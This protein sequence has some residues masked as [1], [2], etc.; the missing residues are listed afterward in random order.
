VLIALPGE[1]VRTAARAGILA[2]LLT[3]A[4]PLSDPGSF[5]HALGAE[6]HTTFV[7]AFSAWW[8]V[9][10]PVHLA[11]GALAAVRALPLG[12]S[13]STATL[14]T[15]ISVLGVLGFTGYRSRRGGGAWDPLALLALLGVVRCFCDTTKL[16]Y[17]YV[18]ALIPLVAW[19]VAA[20][21]RPP[22]LGALLSV[23]TALMPS[24]TLYAHRAALNAVWVGLAV[25]LIVYLR[26]RAFAVWRPPGA[27]AE[28]AV[29][30]GHPARA[31]G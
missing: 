11:G 4:L 9:S 6:G 18:A 3:L 28:T 7:N 31:N 12:L 19:E 23:A 8:P 14:I 25:T 17:Y 21:E 15:L 27:T 29:P 26:H 22:V 1:R 20:L 24:A 16:D 2:A 30:I 13:R 10:S 5:A